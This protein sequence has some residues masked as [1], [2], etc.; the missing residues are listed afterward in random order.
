M[1]NNIVKL[2]TIFNNLKEIRLTLEE[3]LDSLKKTHKILDNIYIDL[4]KDNKNVPV[5]SFDSLYF[6]KTL[7]NIDTQHSFSVLKFI[8]NRI[9]ADYYKLY[10]SLLK[11]FQETIDNKNKTTIFSNK[12]YKPYED[13]NSQIHYS[14]SDTMEM[15]SD[16]LQMIELLHQELIE[17]ETKVKNQRNTKMCGINID[18]LINNIVFNNKKIKNSIELF[19]QNIIGFNEYHSKCL[20][21]FSI[22]IKLL[23]GQIHNDINLENKSNFN[24]D[25]SLNCVLCENEEFMIRELIKNNTNND[26]KTQIELELN[27]IINSI[28]NKNQNNIKISQ[29]IKNKSKEKIKINQENNSYLEYN[30]NNCII[31]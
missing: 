7:I 16:I 2:K 15:Y 5:N 26:E 10:K 20:V 11:Y 23:Y 4:L 3:Q 21:R 8:D 12:N 31:I 1:L 30:I 9:Y 6:Q 27:N 28:S 17:R 25:I 14:F 13:L 19:T 22:R 24:Q 29:N 18:S